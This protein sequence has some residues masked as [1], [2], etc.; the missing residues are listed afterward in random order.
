MAE[1]G[2]ALVCPDWRL[3]VWRSQRW[4]NQKWVT[5]RDWLGVYI[6]LSRFALS[7]KWVQKLGKLP[8][9]FDLW[10][11][12]VYYYNGYWLSSWIHC[13][14]QQ[15]PDFLQVRLNREQ[16]G[17]LSWLL[18][19][20]R[21]AYWTAPCRLGSGEMGCFRILFLYMICISIKMYYLIIKTSCFKKCLD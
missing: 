11:V 19:K 6:W 9:I 4:A 13:Q 15:F 8:D 14:K 16:T 1:H 10:P 3:L 21:L 17:F 7:L 20:S 2:Q 5:I 18:Q 12:E